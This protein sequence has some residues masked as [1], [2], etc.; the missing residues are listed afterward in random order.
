MLIKNRRALAISLIIF[1]CFICLIPVIMSTVN[2]EQESAQPA[3]EVTT[4]NITAIECLDSKNDVILNDTPTMLNDTPILFS[5]LVHNELYDVESSTMYV[6][7]VTS[8][9]D[10][11][12]SALSADN[13]TITAK[14]TMDIEIN[15]LADVIESYMADIEKYLLWEQEHYY[16]AKTFEFLKQRGYSDA[17]ACGIIG[18]MMIETCG[19]SLD[20]LP[21]IYNPTKRF[22]GLCQWSVKYYPEAVNL[23]FEEQL[24]FLDSTIIEEFEVF[25]KLY[26]NGFTYEEFISMSEPTS[27]ALAFA[28]VYERCGSGSYD[29]RK[30]AAEKAYEYFV[31]KER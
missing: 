17:A 8:A 12:K 6:S 11:I 29:L 7:K 26:K 28:K 22:Y 3:T 27:T 19:G 24:K 31:N 23:S 15:R 16:A 21:N 9:I 25:G 2:N 18:N 14:N 1:L 5:R 30:Q 10:I 13:Y 20:L 4:K